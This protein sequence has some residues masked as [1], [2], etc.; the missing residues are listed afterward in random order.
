MAKNA[1]VKSKQGRKQLSPLVKAQRQAVRKKND[2]KDLEEKFDLALGL[3]ESDWASDHGKRVRKAAAARMSAYEDLEEVQ[4]TILEYG[5]NE[6][7][8]SAARVTELKNQR[9][10]FFAKLNDMPELGSTQEEWDAIPEEMKLKRVGRPKL[11]LEQRLIRAR[12]DFQESIEALRAEEAK[13]G[14]KRTKLDEVDDPTLNKEFGR[15]KR[16]RIDQLEA[17][18]RRFQRMVDAIDNGKAE[19]EEK[20]KFDQRETE[21]KGRPRMSLAEKRARYMDRI[22]DFEAQIAHLESGLTPL[23]KAK[24]EVQKVRYSINSI[25]AA[26]RKGELE[27]SSAEVRSLTSLNEKLSGLEQERDRLEMLE[28]QGDEARAEMESRHKQRL[29]VNSARQKAYEDL[30]DKSQKKAKS[31]KTGSALKST[32][33][34][35]GAIR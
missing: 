22:A 19:E 16:S 9:T 6:I 31:K 34:D 33:S 35:I 29:A 15:P 5:R 14:A 13:S 1:T 12:K 10:D 11:S 23:D 27:P 30:K 3:S 28:A 18:K 17:E 2:L 26:M 24:R 21:N 8:L 32:R 4:Q 20:A 25:R 7:S